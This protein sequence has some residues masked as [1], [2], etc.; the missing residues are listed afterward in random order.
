[1][2]KV[3]GRIDKSRQIISLPRDGG[4]GGG[5]GGR[6]EWVGGTHLYRVGPK[7]QYVRQSCRPYTGG[8]PQGW[9]ISFKSFTL[10]PQ[11]CPH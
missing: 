10:M 6:G 7:I 2:I 11:C 1:M 8:I 3:A 4:G 9:H 5:G